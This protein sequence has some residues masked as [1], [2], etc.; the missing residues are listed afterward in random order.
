MPDPVLSDLVRRAPFSFVATVETLGATTTTDVVPDDHTAV[1]LVERVLHAPPAFIKLAGQRVTM[2]MTDSEEPVQVGQTA[3]FFAQVLTIGRSLALTEVGRVSVE[4]LGDRL[5]RPADAGMD[6]PLGDLQE[7]WAAESRRNHAQRSDAMI[8][9]QVVALEKAG[10]TSG[11]EHDPDWW[12]ATIAVR[13]V[14]R[15]DLAEPEV[16]VLYANSR[17]V[18]W[19]RSPKPRPAQN[20]V[21]LLHR[22]SGT[23]AELAPY[24]ILDPDDVQPL[25]RLEGLR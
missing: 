20:A 23:E 2:R 22:T 12:R 11:S 19:L 17:D 7:E 5:H 9:G 14:D 1:V 10:E 15:G 13:H 3:V 16:V 18:A 25:E 8:V 6:S 21:W 24:A 4:Y